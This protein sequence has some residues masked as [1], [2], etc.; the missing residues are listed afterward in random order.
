MLL[1]REQQVILLLAL[2]MLADLVVAAVAAEVVEQ[3][4]QGK[5][6]VQQNM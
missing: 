4:F 1:A 5:L 2:E 6:H 3:G